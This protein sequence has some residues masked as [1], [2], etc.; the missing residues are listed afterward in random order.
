MIR[1]SEFDTNKN[2]SNDE[3]DVLFK[4]LDCY[5]NKDVIVADT[6]REDFDIVPFEGYQVAFKP[7]K[8]FWKSMDFQ[9]RI[10][11]EEKPYIVKLGLWRIN[12]REDDPKCLTKKDFSIITPDREHALTLDFNHVYSEKIFYNIIDI[13]DEKKIISPEAEYSN[14]MYTNKV[15]QNF[16]KKHEWNRII[17]GVNQKPDL[18][19]ALFIIG[20]PSYSWERFHASFGTILYQLI[21]YRN[22]HYS[23]FTKSELLKLDKAIYK[24]RKT[25][26]LRVELI[27]S[28]GV[29]KSY[30]TG[31]ILLDDLYHSSQMRIS[32]RYSVDNGELLKEEESLNN[33]LSLF[34]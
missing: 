34:K 24:L 3:Y 9:K 6:H 10:I 5:R 20:E 11:H 28:T 8:A 26:L 1:P 27:D 15:L 17:E 29:S 32:E 30:P 2:I 33:V 16:I 21:T 25:E 12:P 14:R 22:E 7:N 18:K 4:F 23:E 19:N 31:S 13:F